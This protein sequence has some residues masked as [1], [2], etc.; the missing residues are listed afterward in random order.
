MAFSVNERLGPPT[1]AQGTIFGSA[2]PSWGV[3]TGRSTPFVG[4]TYDA[5]WY[6]ASSDT[7]VV[8]NGGLGVASPA[9]MFWKADPFHPDQAAEISQGPPAFAPGWAGTFD[10]QRSIGV[11]VRGALD[12]DTAYVARTVFQDDAEASGATACWQVVERINGGVITELARF[13]SPVWTYQDDW[14]FYELQ[15]WGSDPVNL[16]LVNKAPL[17]LIGVPPEQAPTMPNF[18]DL[19]YRVDGFDYRHGTTNAY[20]YEPTNGGPAYPYL[21]QRFTPPPSS[22]AVYA[23]ATDARLSAGR[24]WIVWEGTDNSASQ[25][26]AGQPGIHWRR[27]SNQAGQFR[28]RE[29]LEQIHARVISQSGNSATIGGYRP[30]G[31]IVTVT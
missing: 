13:T 9:S 7:P 2:T 20:L 19:T 5:M 3:P 24:A 18:G 27:Q 22:G 12:S 30:P 16:R 8:Q 21:A 15:V 17:E 23:N 29:L 28:A 26:R 14:W 10:S 31:A 1:Y 25:I 11:A 6:G 4:W